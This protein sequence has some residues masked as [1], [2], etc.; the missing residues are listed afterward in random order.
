ME[1]K[2]DWVEK[3]HRAYAHTVALIGDDGMMP[4]TQWTKGKYSIISPCGVTFGRYELYPVDGDVMRF[5]T[6][7][8]AQK[9]ADALPEETN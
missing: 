5:D 2:N 4:K 7:E 9:Y 8:E 6:L 3:E 1:K